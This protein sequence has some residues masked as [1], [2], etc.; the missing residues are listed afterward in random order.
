MPERKRLLDP[1]ELAEQG[2][3][4]A[5]RLPLDLIDP[6]PL[7]PRQSLPDIEGL[8]ANIKQLKGLIEPV[9]VWRTGAR[10]MLLSGHRRWAAFLQLAEQEP[11]EPQWRSIPAVIKTGDEATAELILVSAE[12]HHERWKPKE[13]APILER[14]H[15][16]GLSM[17]EIGRRLN[18]S[19]S[20]VSYR[21]GVYADPVLAPMALAETLPVTV[22]QE[23]LRIADPE[24]RRRLAEQAAAEA[25]SQPRARLEVRKLYKAEQVRRLGPQARAMMEAL[26]G[27]KASQIPRADAEELLK[28]ARLITQ[29]ARG[30]QKV[31]P[32][33]EAAE[34]AAGI[35]PGART[36]K[37]QPRRRM[38]PRPS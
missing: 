10:Y 15:K 29:M 4:E 24:A 9:A 28:L 8:A 32:S 30:A 34:R 11:T 23:F 17:N 19:E 7:N 13:E 33:I 5:V 3:P 31:L 37:A 16:G 14:W 1:A 18:K 27:V 35:R 36:R 12:V 6:N 26:A 25:W 2:P 20:W 22:L 38:M 21:M